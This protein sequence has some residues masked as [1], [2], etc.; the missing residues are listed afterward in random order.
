MHGCSLS[1]DGKELEESSARGGAAALG[2]G[3]KGDGDE[4]PGRGA[5]NKAAHGVGASKRAEK[6]KILEDGEC[7]DGNGHDVDGLNAGHTNNDSGDK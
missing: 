5:R 2:D 7:V 3:D 6:P 4:L 1:K